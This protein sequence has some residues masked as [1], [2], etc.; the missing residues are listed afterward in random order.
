MSGAHRGALTLWPFL[1]TISWQHALVTS[2]NNDSHHPHTPHRKQWEHN[3]SNKKRGFRSEAAR[4]Q[5]HCNRQQKRNDHRCR[6]R[7]CNSRM[8]C[9]VEENGGGGLGAHFPGRTRKIETSA[10]ERR[11]SSLKHAPLRGAPQPQQSQWNTNV[12]NL[13]TQT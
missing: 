11:A 8:L 6:Y 4:L 9:G 7:W 5:R 10:L 12:T 1:L 13:W 3:R 2:S